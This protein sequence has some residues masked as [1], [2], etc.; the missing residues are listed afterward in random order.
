MGSRETTS[1]QKSLS[2]SL[3]TLEQRIMLAADLQLEEESLQRSKADTTQSQ[4][5]VTDSLSDTESAESG[6]LQDSSSLKITTSSGAVVGVD[7][8]DC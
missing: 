5:N 1:Q 2:F 6:V 8:R 4:E 7:R 3:E